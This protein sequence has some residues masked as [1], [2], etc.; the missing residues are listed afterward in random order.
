VAVVRL[1]V[2]PVAVDEFRDGQVGYLVGGRQAPAVRLP[3]Q[4]NTFLF[5]FAGGR[6]VLA[7]QP[8]LALPGGSIRKGND[9]LTGLAVKAVRGDTWFGGH[10]CLPG[11]MRGRFRAIPGFPAAL[12]DADRYA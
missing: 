2:F 12:S 5:R 9:G 3:V 8:V 7:D 4:D 6:I 10:A 11:M 1:D